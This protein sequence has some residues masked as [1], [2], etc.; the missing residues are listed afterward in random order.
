MALLEKVPIIAV[1]REK[2][3]TL[4]SVAD[5]KK[6]SSVGLFLLADDN[7]LKTQ[8]VLSSRPVAI[9]HRAVL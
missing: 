6:H 4:G 1:I 8:T 5:D 7:I 9:I 2:S 3:K